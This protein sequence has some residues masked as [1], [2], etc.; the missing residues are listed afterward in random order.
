[1]DSKKRDFSKD[2]DAG[3]LKRYR[4]SD[5]FGMTEDFRIITSRLLVQKQD[6]AKIIGKG[7]HMIT[8]IR[9]KFGV[10]LKGIEID[11]N[12]RLISIC[13]TLS[14]LVGTFDTIG[15]ILYNS[16][17]SKVQTTSSSSQSL[18]LPLEQFS[19]TLMIEN[20]MAGRVIGAKGSMITQLKIRSGTQ[21]AKMVKD[22]QDIE[23][24]LIRLTGYISLDVEVEVFNLL[25]IEVK[26][27]GDLKMRQLVLDGT[28]DAIQRIYPLILRVMAD[29]HSNSNSGNL[30]VVDTQTH[31]NT[32]TTPVPVPVPVLHSQSM[33]HGH[34][35]AVPPS[36]VSSLS[37]QQQ[38]WT[39]LGGVSS[40]SGVG[41]GATSLP[42]PVVSLNSLAMLGVH[43]DAI[44]Q[45][46]DLRNYLAAFSLDVVVLEKGVG[47]LPQQQQQPP[48]SQSQSQSFSSSY[49][50]NGPVAAAAADAVHVHLSPHMATLSTN[51][52]NH[53]NNHS[54]TSNS[55]INNNNNNNSYVQNQNTHRHYSKHE[56]DQLKKERRVLIPSG[57][58]GSVIGK[59]ACTLKALQKEFGTF[60][61]VEKEEAGGMRVVKLR[62]DN[63]DM[64]NR[65]RERIIRLCQN[66]P[67]TVTA[68]VTAPLSEPGPGYS[69]CANN[70]VSSGDSYSDTT[71]TTTTLHPP[72]DD[73]VNNVTSVERNSATSQG[74]VDDLDNNDSLVGGDGFDAD[75]RERNVSN[76]GTCDEDNA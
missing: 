72:P 75:S 38:H 8:N 51:Y 17:L 23:H 49:H 60:I 22:I 50:D 19:I 42:L 37:S 52:N 39:H 71:T 30:S 67:V 28:L 76:V 35:R 26:V 12:Q 45:L 34:G 7:G 55:S 53:S 25:Q 20:D 10:E 29:N 5:D 65:A 44:R 63:D 64:L 70:I 54:N 3:E 48:H 43:T 56:S 33:G 69:T 74:Q 1:M 47:L 18:P 14:Q 66:S 13:G 9:S 40:G 16:F 62:G 73:D 6:F 57:K 36:V 32:S 21:H 11:E 24:R 68:T 58:V 61:C 59:G 31:M 15:E 4:S 27:V 41:G 2:E 46:V